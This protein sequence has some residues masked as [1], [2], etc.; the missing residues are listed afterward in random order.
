ME[1]TSRRAVSL[2]LAGS[3]LMLCL[4]AHA[5]GFRNPPDTA[6]ALGKA[7]KTIVWVD[8]A[9]AV[10]YN[11]ANLTDVSTR[12]LQLSG[13]LGYSSAEYSGAAGD[14]ET[15]SP[16][17]LLPGLALAWP[18]PRQDMSFGLGV[19]VPY[20]RQTCWD[21]RG[22]FRY[23]APSESKMS[24]VDIT[25]ALAWRP[26]DNLSIGAGLDLYYGQLSFRQYLPWPGGEGKA[27]AEA[28]G[29]AMGANAGVSWRPTPRQRLALTCRLPF[30]LDF[31]GDLDVEATGMG[32]SKSDLRTTFSFPTIVALGYGF[33]VTE[34]L[35]V[36]ADVEWLEF[37]RYETLE[38][39]AGTNQPLLEQMGMASTAQDWKDTWTAGVSAEWRFAKN[40]TLRSGYLYLESPIPDTTFSPAMLDQS[41][42]VVSLGL[43]FHTGRHTVDLAYALG[44]FPTREVR[45][46]QNPA[47]NGDYDFAGHLAALS[48]T[49]A[50]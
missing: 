36:E 46:N 11:P 37:S 47:Y 49:I 16:W 21:E 33:Q 29:W 44:L 14:T 15:E 34:D 4:G 13:L 10:F 31:E 5:D 38:L 27:T 6:A 23:S 39:D 25:P 17:A 48:Y 32:S 28:D 42:S 41:Q 24:V 2:H 43:G 40:W 18:L 19:H 45:G 12:Q 35:R 50:F 8:D 9:S 1:M 7:G 22:L 20:G 30:D 3:V 26:V